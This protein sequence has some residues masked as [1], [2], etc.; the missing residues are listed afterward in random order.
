MT[1]QMDSRIANKNRQNVAP[2]AV[3]LVAVL[4]G[5]LAFG[6]LMSLSRGTVRA[7]GLVRHAVGQNAQDPNNLKRHLADAKGVAEALKKKNLFVPPPPKTHPVKQVDGILGSEA[8]IAGK[9]YKAGEKVGD[10]KIVAVGATEVKVEWDGKETAFAPMAAA[11]APPPPG[12]PPREPKKEPGPPSPKAA[13]SAVVV[14]K[15]AEPAAEDPLAWVGVPLS[16]QMREKLLAKWNE[17][18]DEQKEMIKERW[19]GMSDEEKQKALE[20]AGK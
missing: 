4:L 14:E 20:E 6:K 19:G 13:P 11:S 8:L 15:K 7:E 12:G 3:G 17:A 2:L 10:A 5:V 9:W 16:P 1:L 18:S